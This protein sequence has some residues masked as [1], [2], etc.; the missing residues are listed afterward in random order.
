M[1]KKIIERLLILLD[2]FNNPIGI[3][4]VIVAFLIGIL[5]CICG[6]VKSRIICAC[7]LL[8]IAIFSIVICIF[9]NSPYCLILLIFI[10]P[11]FAITL[12]IFLVYD[13][14]RL[15]IKYKK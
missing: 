13:F 11:F 2:I 15:L 7:S 12:I 14:V 8:T 6:N 3:T 5:M 9:G 1:I 10:I 4:S